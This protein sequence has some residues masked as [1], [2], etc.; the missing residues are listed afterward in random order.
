MVMQRSHGRAY[1]LVAP[2]DELPEGRAA[3]PEPVERRQDGTVASPEAAKALGKR[4][5][6]ARARRRAA[7]ATAGARLRLGR[8]LSDLR[9]SEHVAP[10]VNEAER[11]LDATAAELAASTGGGR[12]SPMVTSV[13]QS[14]AWARAFSSFF[15]DAASRETWAWDRA[16]EGVKPAVRPS[17]DLALAASRLATESR[18]H[19]IAA[20]ELAAREAESRPREALADMQARILGGGK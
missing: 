13:L 10:F 7:I 1:P 12:L 16:P 6:A 20:F 8:Y 3:E 5:G 18:Q 4:G 19:C 14:A 2:V 11:W 9:A 15:Y 17:T